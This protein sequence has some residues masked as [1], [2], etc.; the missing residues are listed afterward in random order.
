[1]VTDLAVRLLNQPG[2]GSDVENRGAR[3]V[4]VRDKAEEQINL[5]AP[6]GIS[7]NGIAVPLRYVIR[8]EPYI[9][10]AH[11][12]SLYNNRSKPGVIVTSV[13]GSSP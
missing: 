4:V 2:T 5:L 12:T 11:G 1:M 13:G 8:I 6:H 10:V 3:N 9:R 7:R